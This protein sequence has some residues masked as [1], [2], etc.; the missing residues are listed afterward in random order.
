MIEVKNTD[1]NMVTIVV[2]CNQHV[3]QQV[4]TK[5]TFKT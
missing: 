4:L 3:K 5:C 2:I 1:V